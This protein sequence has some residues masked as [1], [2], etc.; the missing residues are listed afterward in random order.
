MRALVIALLVVLL[1]APAAS[2]AP[3]RCA[4]TDVVATP[5]NLDTIRDS[6]ACLHNQARAGKRMRAL[7]Q[8][9][10]LAEAAAGHADDMV[11]RGYFEHETPEGGHFDERISATGYLRRANGWKVAENLI[12]ATGSLTTPS[13]LMRA[14]L[15]SAG[16]RA[17]ILNRAYREIGFGLTYGTPD[18]VA[19][20]TIAAEFGARN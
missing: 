15:E 19:G 9:R 20:V 2:A 1:M 14:W 10:A 12:W 4:N 5:E 3:R 7:T 18:G 13:A 17:N 16:H 6:L 11:A 8:N